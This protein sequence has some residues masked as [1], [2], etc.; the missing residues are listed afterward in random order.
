MPLAAKAS[1]SQM[2]CLNSVPRPSAPEHVAHTTETKIV[3]WALCYEQELEISWWTK[4]LGSIEK[5][6]SQIRSLKRV[7]QVDYWVWAMSG[8]FP[9]I[10]LEESCR[11]SIYMGTPK[12]P[13]KLVLGSNPFNVFCLTGQWRLAL[14]HYVAQLAAVTYSSLILGLSFSPMYSMQYAL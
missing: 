11:S 14:C 4:Y 13:W 2:E 1:C 6:I 12:T 8:I 3:M 9:V 5:G 7:L 10:T